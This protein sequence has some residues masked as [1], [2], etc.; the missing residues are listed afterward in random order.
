MGLKRRDFLKIG[1][2]A[3]ATVALG[4]K[5]L[6]AMEFAD[7]GVTASH[8][9]GAPRV[10]AVPYTCLQCNIEDGG[11]AFIEDGRVVKLE[12]NPKHPGNRGKL[13]AK[14]NAGINGLYDPDRILYPMRR[15]G[16]RGE[17]KWK[18]VSW[19]EAYKELAS[20]MAEVQAL[21]RP[22]PRRP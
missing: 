8:V 4:P 11:L 13:C 16:K 22:H 19:D 1:A 15:V 10:E 7:G 20:R 21:Y 3:T 12:G 14:G 18:R 2:A 17:G 9:T 5:V 6:K